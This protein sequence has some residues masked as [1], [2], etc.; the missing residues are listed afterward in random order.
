[1]TKFEGL[2][3]RL[4]EAWAKTDE[5]ERKSTIAISQILT[6][7]AD[8]LEVPEDQRI[9]AKPSEGLSPEY[10][11]SSLNAPERQDDNTWAGNLVME[12]DGATKSR[13]GF[14][15]FVDF[16]ESGADFWMRGDERPFHI[17]RCEP[18]EMEPFFDHV[19]T[20]VL[21]ELSEVGGQVPQKNPVG[22]IWSR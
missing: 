9:F 13:L 3:E 11:S 4:D 17:L 18:S 5:R 10:G 1:M 22:F 7:F 21:K 2:K 20:N 16:Q 8:Y 6:K 14:T 19:Y 12:T 15:I